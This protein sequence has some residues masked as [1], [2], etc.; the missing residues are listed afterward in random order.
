MAASV[1]LPARHRTAGDSGPRPQP[2]SEAAVHEV[3]H[4]RRRRPEWVPGRRCPGGR[5]PARRSAGHSAVHRPA[6]SS[7][8]PA[9]WLAFGHGDTVW[10]GEN[11]RLRIHLAER[12]GSLRA[13]PRMRSAEV[14]VLHRDQMG[15]A[16]HRGLSSAPPIRSA[17]TSPVPRGFG[18]VRWK[19]VTEF[20]P[21][22]TQFSQRLPNVLVTGFFL[23][24][25][26]AARRKDGTAAGVN[27][28]MDR[29]TVHGLFHST[30]QPYQHLGVQSNRIMCHECLFGTAVSAGTTAPDADQTSRHTPCPTA[31]SPT[32]ARA[33][34]QRTMRT[35]RRN[36]PPGVL[37]RLPDWGEPPTTLPAGP[38]AGCAPR[39]IRER[40]PRPRTGDRRDGRAAHRLPPGAGDDPRVPRG[41]V[42][43]AFSR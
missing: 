31:R 38:A 7:R 16:R 37:G 5:G 3:G 29:E 8:R 25:A 11:R 27:A 28:V 15:T 4:G 22:L 23:G 18:K 14:P 24:P 40:R 32:L 42:A 1:S 19:V 35:A 9:W 2:Q 39:S 34:S 30:Q 6:R 36:W 12:T 10:R 43:P 17:V 26:R 20:S 21:G 41:L 13:Q 33:T